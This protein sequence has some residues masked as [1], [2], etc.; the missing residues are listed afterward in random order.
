MG[1]TQS[2]NYETERNTTVPCTPSTAALSSTFALGA[3]CYWGTEKFIIKGNSLLLQGK[4]THT[5]IYT[6]DVNVIQQ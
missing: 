3:G 1:Q 4:K 5:F 6:N 2:S